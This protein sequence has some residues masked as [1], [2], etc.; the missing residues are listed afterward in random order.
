MVSGLSDTIFADSSGQG[1]ASLMVF[2]LSGNGVKQVLQTLVGKLPPPRY[3]SLCNIKNEKSEIIDNAL[4]IFFPAPHSYTGE[5]MA[6]LQCHA[7]RAI[8][9]ALSDLLANIH[10]LRMAEPGEFSYRAFRYG[11]INLI[12]AEA[13]NDLAM[14]ETEWQRKTAL[15]QWR[16]DKGSLS[17]WLITYREK[18]ISL[19]AFFETLIDFYDM[20]IPQD[21]AEQNLKE[22]A[23]WIVDTK[24]LTDDNRATLRQNGITI[25]IIGAPNVGKSSL[26]NL[27]AKREVAIVSSTAGTTRDVIELHLDMFGYRV[28]FYDTAGLRRSKNKLEK[29][30]IA[31]A[32]HLADIADIRIIIKDIFLEGKDVANTKWQKQKTDIVLANKADI[33]TDNDLKKKLTSFL[34]K[35]DIV[36]STKTDIGMAQFLKKLCSSIEILAGGTLQGITNDRQRAA[37]QKSLHHAELAYLA[38][39]SDIAA[40]ELKLAIEPLD[41]LL[42]YT[43]NDD[44]LGIIFQNFCI[45]K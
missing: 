41:M 14:A 34:A 36:F 44:M 11:K 19:K 25:A 17:Q 32:E 3:A 20:D 9:Q 16:G 31:K 15:A 12:E 22:L 10:G 30:G 4:V 29:L 42:G 24:K 28:V 8:K 40:E 21:L 35:G 45:G 26:I 1:R 37:L 38:T 23:H 2:R 6:E 7:S 33:I 27:L 18:L 43:T 5:D 13:I 39:S